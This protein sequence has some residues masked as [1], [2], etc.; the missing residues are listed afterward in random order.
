[1]SLYGLDR[2]LELAQNGIDA[3]ESLG[4]IDLR[5]EQQLLGRIGKGARGGRGGDTGGQEGAAVA[6]LAALCRV[7]IHDLT[8]RRGFHWCRW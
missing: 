7:R 6:Q 5:V 2:L 8:G 1:M 4:I 3:L